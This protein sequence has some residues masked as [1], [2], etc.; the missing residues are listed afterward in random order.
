MQNS[1]SRQFEGLLTR[2]F[3]GELADDPVAAS[4]AGLREG[5]GRLGNAGAHHEAK[6]QRRRLRTLRALDN[7]CLRELGGEQHLDRLALRCYLLH[8]AEDF[9]RGRSQLEPDAIDH[10]L[11]VL[12]HELQRGEDEPNRAARNIRSLLRQAPDYLAESARLIKRPEK[13]WRDVMFET[14]AGAASLLDATETF[15]QRTRP[16]ADDAATLRSVSRAIESYRARVADRPLAPRNSFAVGRAIVERRVRDELGLD[17]TLEQI[18]TLAGNE[19]RRIGALLEKACAR[20]GR[21]KSAAEILSRARADWNPSGDLFSLYQKETARMAAAFKRAKAVTFPTGE[22]LVLRP[23]PDFMKPL[24]PTAAYSAPGA[25]EKKQRG[26]FWVNDLS[27]DKKTPAEKRAER[28]QH[29]GISL[30]CAHEA[31]PGHHLQ[32]AIANQHPRKWRRLFAHAV[33]YEGWTLWCEQLT[34]D[35]QIDRSPWAPVQQLKDALW[36]CHRI[37]ID[38]RLQTGR[39]TYEQGVNHLV[40][41]LGFSRARARAEINW[42]TGSPCVPMSYW[43]GRLENERLYRR[44]VVGRGWSLQRFND[45]LLSFGTLP[46]SWLEKYGLD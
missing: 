19:I 31:Y 45:W 18:E 21:G 28:Q 38:L 11:N 30:T 16:A 13:V 17:Y 5:E 44:L 6:Q 43:L 32:F 36:R 12:F 27:L 15:L 24:L 9:E 4:M 1:T 46:Q 29:F 7:C 20:F 35:L 40:R 34:V 33:F 14:A 2:H 3:E 25:F 41:H 23:A 22:S 39:Y 8:G 42:Y 26:I 10:V 37:V